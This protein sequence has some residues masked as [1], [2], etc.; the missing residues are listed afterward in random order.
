MNAESQRKYGV[1]L[2]PTGSRSSYRPYA[3]Q[4]YFWNLYVSGRGNLAARPGTS[5]HGWG[6]A[7]DVATPQMRSIVDKIGAK[8]GWAK[9]WSD[10]PSEW[11]HLKWKPGKYAAVK[12]VK[13]DPV[14]K[15]KS[16]GPS[17]VKLKKLL[18]DKGI[19]DFSSTVTGKPNNNRYNPF[20]GKNTDKA[21]K[22]F[23]REHNLPTDGVV[24]PKTWTALRK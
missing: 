24:G 19:R 17:V 23:Q 7:V 14:L 13:V 11:W 1:T 2:R 15:Y 12:N 16:R 20:F 10:A 18:Y 5:N 6:L 22:R 4:L 21:V 3:D 8:Y 9:R